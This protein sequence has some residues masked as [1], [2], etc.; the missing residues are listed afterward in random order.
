MCL[1]AAPV[2]VR[3]RVVTGVV[4]HPELRPS[5]RVTCALN[6]PVYSSAPHAQILYP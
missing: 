1:N 5:L 2:K 3:A 6:C 4:S